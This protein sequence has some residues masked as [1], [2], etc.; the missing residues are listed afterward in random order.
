MITFISPKKAVNAVFYRLPVLQTEM[1]RLK[2]N[3][4]IYLKSG[5]ADESE[6]FHKNLIKDFLANTFFSPDYAVNTNGREDL[7]IFN[8]NNAASKPAVII[9]AKSPTNLAE[10]FS[11]NNRNCKALQECVYYFMQENLRFGNNE[12]KHIIV[13]NYNDFYIFDAKDFSRFFL[14]KTNPIV[15]QFKKFDAGQLSDTKT[16]YFYEN[17]AKPAI[18]RW[19]ENENVV[20]THFSKDD[21]AKY[22]KNGKDNGLLPLYKILSPE[23]LLNKPFANDSNSLDKNFYEELLHIVGLEEVKESGKKVIRRRK[24]SERDSA[25]LIESAIYQLEEDILNENERFETA[26]RLVINWVNRLIFLKLVESQQLAYQK[27]NPE[28]KFLTIELV[29][30]FDE[31]NILFFKV[32]GRKPEKRDEQV[33]EKFRFVPYLN[34][35]LFEQSDEEKLLQIRGIMNKPMKIFAHTVLKDDKGRKMSGNIDNLAYIFRFLD[36]YNFSSETEGGITQNTKT[37]INASVLGLIFEKI[38]G[39]KDGSFFTPG[40]IT[41]YMAKETIERAVVQKF[42]DVKSWKCETLDEIRDK[43]EDRKDAN[44]IINSLR[45]CDPAVGSGHFLVSVLNRILYI[46]SY[47][48]ILLD[49][50]GLRI[51]RS[52]WELCLENDEISILDDEGNPF[53]YSVNSERQRVQETIFGEKRKIIENCLFGVDINPASVYICRLRLWIELLKNAYYTKES[54]F[55]QLETLPNIDINIKCGNSLVSRYSIKTGS[56]VLNEGNPDTRRLIKQYREA[57]AAYKNENNKEN[58]RKV[59]TLIASIKRQIHGVAQLTLFD[60]ELNKKIL[61]DDIYA[62]SLEWMIEFPEVLA[63]TGKFLG[64]DA[65][66]GNPPYISAP[67]QVADEKMKKQ[68]EALVH[69]REYQ[70]LYQKWDIYVPFVELGLKLGRENAICAMIVPFPLTNQVYAKQLRRMIVEN[71]LFELANLNGTK[72]FDEATVSNCIPFV[73]KSAAT[74]KTWIS[75][76]DDNMKISRAFSQ[77]YSDL[78]QDTDTFIWNV[79]EE[80]RET[81]RHA[82]MHVLGDFCYISVGM[83][84]NSDEKTAKGEFSKDDLISETADEI[85]CRKYVEAKDLTKYG[86][87]RIRF[88][89]Y[90]TERVPNKLRRPTFKEMYTTP[91]ILMNGFGEINAVIDFREKILHNHT[92]YCGILWKDLCGVENKSILN[93]IK[94]FSTMTRVDM[95]KLSETVDL[96]YLLGIMNSKYASVLLTNL[97]G[98]DFHIYPEHIRNIPIPTATHEQQKPIIDLVDRILA[99]KAADH[100]ADTSADEH[101]IDLQVYHLYGL[102]FDEAKVIDP[103]L[104]EEEFEAVK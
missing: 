103:E 22:I 60:E 11:E 9:E 99:A 25:S 78:I 67:A 62:N 24:E 96:R 65:V 12:V 50:N 49:K 38:N 51:R 32:L 1:E 10:M 66:I 6:E 73:K 69:R 102:T 61:D 5:K 7:V 28:Y 88:L 89:E 64:F 75:K 57:V 76:I 48:D 30:N 77:L 72:V 79:T 4:E 58:K 29:P 26:L 42:N 20:V 36:A 55:T 83:V 90:E 104:K 54:D 59:D 94:K 71:D 82:D 18:E 13:T 35:S 98:S 85:H 16:S 63:D 91:K 2:S 93:S 68:R 27:G 56:S 97:R 86:F 33:K 87:N 14:A 95:E 84:L 70:S 19:I 100:N 8:G 23:H 45:I 46:K 43:I 92:V 74:G 44:E 39:Y 21:F 40:F 53:I 34:S 52:D 37:L 47:L 3:F 101:K 17:C 15:E 41:E 80:K 31:L 81:N